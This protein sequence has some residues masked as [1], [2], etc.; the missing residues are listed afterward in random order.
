MLDTSRPGEGGPG[1]GQLQ[2]A[3]HRRHEAQG[4]V[5]SDPVVEFAECPD[6]PVELE[7]VRDLLA[8]RV[9]VLE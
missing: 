5:R 8:E 1:I 9:P 6:V 2:K 7:H 4:L 3:R